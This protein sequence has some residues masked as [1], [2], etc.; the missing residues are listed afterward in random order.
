MRLYQVAAGASTT[1]F[2]YDGLDLIAEYDGSGNV[3]RRHIFAPDSS[4]SPGQGM[5][6]PI[7]T[8]EGP[9]TTS[10][11]ARFLSADER[12]G[13]IGVSDSSGAAIA[14]NT[15]DEYGI[16]GSGNSGRFQYTGQALIPEV[17]LYYYKARMY[18]TVLGRANVVIGGA[19]LAYDAA[20]IAI[21]TARDK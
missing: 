6:R 15:Y 12:G 2:A 17:G 8:Y 11:S 9:D 14:I 18:S 5:D 13:I 19:L 7:L 20:S 10:G 3:L 4:S 21:C 1:R 16:P